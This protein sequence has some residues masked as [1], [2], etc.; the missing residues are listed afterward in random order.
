MTD[1]TATH[2][3]RGPP[4]GRR[5]RPPRAGAQGRRRGPA[6]EARPGPAGGRRGL[7]PR[8]LLDLVGF[9]VRGRPDPDADLGRPARA[10]A[11]PW[12][13]ACSSASRWPASC[14]SG[15][16]AWW[17]SS[18]PRPTASSRPSPGSRPARRVATDHRPS[19]RVLHPGCERP[20]SKALS[21][22]RRA[23]PISRRD[24][25]HR[26]ENGARRAWSVTS[27]VLDD[28]TAAEGRASRASAEGDA[29][30]WWGRWVGRPPADCCMDRIAAGPTATAAGGGG[31]RLRRRRRP[32]AHPRDPGCR[33]SRA[34]DRRHPHGTRPHLSRSHR[35][36][37]VRGA[38][39]VEVA[40]RPW[41]CWMLVGRCPHPA[42][43]SGARGP[44]CPAP[45]RHGSSAGARV[46]VA[47][48]WRSPAPVTGL[49][50]GPPRGSSR[51]AGEAGGLKAPRSGCTALR[52]VV[53]VADR[54]G[55]VGAA[56]VLSRSWLAG[57][58]QNRRAVTAGRNWNVF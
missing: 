20:I 52:P 27:G 29:G 50:T 19:Q 34:A 23:E 25:E 35:P 22:R 36:A 49:A 12:A 41:L 1:P 28:G 51:G 8:R 38:V 45:V 3:A 58:P 40:A 46:S 7:D 4:R 43:M 53:V 31:R 33:P 57:T 2:V 26:L 24:A 37:P 42:A 17:S 10:S 30:A 54:S 16:P 18:R 14:A 32:P 21:S 9:Q 6:A 56:G 48:R 39:A 11:W 47:A 55:S 44:L 15:W 13:S 5:G